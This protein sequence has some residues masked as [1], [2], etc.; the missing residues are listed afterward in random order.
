M[1]FRS[2]EGELL[3][4]ER[5]STRVIEYCG[6]RGLAMGQGRHL[7]KLS[8]VSESCFDTI[9]TPTYASIYVSSNEVLDR[10]NVSRVWASLELK[11]RLC[12]NSIVATRA[13]R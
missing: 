1:K 9:A 2:S 5:E 12:E 13:P 8:L 11:Y 10:P 7:S 3:R 4:G 6:T